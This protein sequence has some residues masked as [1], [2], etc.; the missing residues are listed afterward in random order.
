[1]RPTA[2]D[3][4]EQLLS[5][6]PNGDTSADLFALTLL[7]TDI[8]DTAAQANAADRE[9]PSLNDQREQQREEAAKAQADEEEQRLEEERKLAQTSQR[10]Q[11]QLFR[12]QLR[13]QRQQQREAKRKNRPV[14]Q[15]SIKHDWEELLVDITFA[16]PFELRLLS[17]PRP[18]H[19][20]AILHQVSQDECGRL[21]TAAPIMPEGRLDEPLQSLRQ[22]EI[23]ETFLDEAKKQRLERLERDVEILRTMDDHL[24]R[25]LALKIEKQ[26]DADSVGL[27][28]IITV[29]EMANQ[30]SVESVLQCT[31]A[32]SSTKV[33]LWALEI[34]QGL[35]ALHSRGLAH[36][37]LDIGA[38]KLNKASNSDAVS[39]QLA[40]S[41]VREHLRSLV[42]KQGTMGSRAASPTPTA[43]THPSVNCDEVGGS[44]HV[45]LWDFGVLLVQMAAGPLALHD[46]ATPDSFIASAQL[47]F[48]FEELLTRCFRSN[49]NKKVRAFDLIMS[50]FLSSDDDCYEVS[51][52]AV[53]KQPFI[54]S[55][56][57]RRPSGPTPNSLLGRYA[58]EFNEIMR[59]GRGGQGVVVKARHKISNRFYAIKKIRPSSKGSLEELYAEVILLSQ[60]S[61]PN[62]IRYITAWVE[63]QASNS[64][65]DG[66]Q[67]SLSDAST[68]FQTGNPVEYQPGSVAMEFVSRAEMVSHFSARAGSLQIE[69]ADS[70]GD[71]SESKSESESEASYLSEGSKSPD[72]VGS[73]LETDGAS[74]STQSQSLH[75]APMRRVSSVPSAS[76]LY[77]QMELADSNT[78]VN[79]INQGLPDD[80]DEGW[81]L[82]RQ[83]L[84]ALQY[85]H[86]LGIIHRDLK[87]LNIFIDK[88]KNVKLGDFGLATTER[89][90]S[91]SSSQGQGGYQGIGTYLGRTDLDLSTNVGTQTYMAP[92]MRSIGAG[93]YT[94]KVDM[95][96][97]GLVFFEMCYRLGTGFERAHVI[98]SLKQTIAFP[99]AWP[100]D[101]SVQRQIITSLLDHK[102]I[103]RPTSA[104]LLEGGLLPAPGEDALVQQ[105][106][107]RLAAGQTTYHEQL[108]S[109]LF[110]R[111]LDA[112]QDFAWDTLRPL[113][114]QADISLQNNVREKL[115]TVFKRHGALWF[116]RPTIFPKSSFNKG[117]T[118]QVLDRSG[119][120]LQLPFDT[121][122]PIAR[123]LAKRGPQVGKLFSFS[124]IYR[125]NRDAMPGVFPLLDWDI[126][127]AAG[128]DLAMA[129]AEVIVVMNETL[130]AFP[131]IYTTSNMMFVVS[132][133]R[134]LDIILDH[135]RITNNRGAVRAILSRLNIQDFGWSKAK[136]EFG[137]LYITAT[138]LEDLQCFDF[139]D[140][141]ETAFQKM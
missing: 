8:L 68:S 126:I 48:S 61:H 129:D 136:V 6:W 39:I 141:P 101:R 58:H 62:I 17:G 133:G 116:D 11:Q 65:S 43:W 117:N 30:G 100:S 98:G 127:S 111:S 88:D 81:R 66:D 131:S 86:D 53:V 132:H 1:M 72:G 57:P 139:R 21:Y 102:P 112:A 9:T 118:L 122:V 137:T 55:R 10:E 54:E 59:L 51:G 45:D 128:D 19:Q 47:T 31:G 74:R 29:T 82:F 130:D 32:V 78:L 27:W 76:V 2:L 73:S 35:D 24:V 83:I 84:E 79:L 94:E 105:I 69:F 119:N 85:I 26:I 91:T 12:D 124:Q 109:A 135:C 64:T 123:L 121:T 70:E 46:Y 41:C 25:F 110:S 63:E 34:L 20:L 60:I 107:R 52:H 22:L 97:L 18:C 4:V 113:Y 49:P 7:L 13:K 99:Q 67:S 71:D 3:S 89:F 95:Y 44:K 104:A 115:T 42:A 16:R 90:T 92:E 87:P 15:A 5:T 50:K 125:E 103:T 134:L 80:S 120:V 93:T 140:D 23:I 108:L 77:I 37:S 38:L 28:S 138:S 36:G 56:T 96:S 106:L 114:T 75:P 14:D 40:D 33:R